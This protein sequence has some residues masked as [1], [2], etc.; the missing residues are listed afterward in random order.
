MFKKIFAFLL[1]MGMV[2]ATGCA[3]DVGEGP[4]IPTSEPTEPTEQR[5]LD[6]NGD[7][8]I[9]WFALGDSITQGYYSVMEDGKGVLKLN[10][11]VA[12]STL[13]SKEVGWRLVNSAVGGSGYVH[14]GT[15]LDKL[16]ARDHMDRMTFLQA[17]LVTLAFGI[18]DWKGNQPLGSMDDDVQQG[19]TFYSNM[20][21]CIE[22]IMAENPNAEI[23]VI[24][25][26]NC[27]RFG[28]EASQWSI[29]YRF[30]RSGTL[31]DVFNAMQEVCDYYGLPMIDLL[32]N[33]EINGD[34]KNWFPDGVHP[35][36]EKHQRLA[37]ILQEEL[38]LV[39]PLDWI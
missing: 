24:S 26:M 16:N 12:W 18:N 19:G 27:C 32:H 9:N 7:G 8:H 13:L 4:T 28:N 29:G 15:V 3:A 21:Y 31:E 38:M 36:Q 22:K 5:T 1:A 37:Q 6:D 25:P 17:E 23:V 2:V 14:P 20:C 11:A 35:S 10:S 30:A 34:I 39:L 33:E